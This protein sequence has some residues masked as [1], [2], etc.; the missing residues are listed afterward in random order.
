MLWKSFIQLLIPL[1]RF[2]PLS[3]SRLK[4]FLLFE[5]AANIFDRH[6]FSLK[7]NISSPLQK[8]SLGPA[9]LE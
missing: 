7:T 6:N 2:S 4:L 8:A 5:N 3:L 9:K 1:S